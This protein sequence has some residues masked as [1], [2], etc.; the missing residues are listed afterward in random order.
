[1]TLLLFFFCFEIF[2]FLLCTTQK[3]KNRHMDIQSTTLTFDPDYINS[4]NYIPSHAHYPPLLVNNIIARFNLNVEQLNLTALA[5][6]FG[7]NVLPLKYGSN[8]RTKRKLMIEVRKR[9]DQRYS[10][11]PTPI[12]ACIEQLKH[13]N[14]L[15]EMY[16]RCNQL[17]R[18]NRMRAS[19]RAGDYAYKVIDFTEPWA[20]QCTLMLYA[21][22]KC[23]VSGIRSEQQGLFVCHSFVRY[24]VETCHLPVELRDFEIR[25]IACD[26]QLGYDVDL[27]ALADAMPERACYDPKVYPACIIYDNVDQSLVSLVYPNGKIVET[28]AKSYAQNIPRHHNI[29]DL[30]A[31]FRV[32]TGDVRNTNIRDIREARLTTDLHK[33]N[34]RQLHD[35]NQILRRLT[36]VRKLETIDEDDDNNNN[37]GD[38]DDDSIDDDIVNMVDNEESVH[39]MQVRK[40]TEMQQR[41]I[42]R[43]QRKH[44]RI[45][46]KSNTGVSTLDLLNDDDDDDNTSSNVGRKRKRVE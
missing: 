27:R 28:G 43:A 45:T 15:D 42:D 25:N 35:A 2:L 46:S 39:N 36:N 9:S 6:K 18:L 19:I 8:N 24:L 17:T 41:M 22:G 5:Q 3:Q 33:Q 34:R 26:T 11:I 16:H 21:G 1:M 7:T 44:L 40:Q 13:H 38:D 10:H 29:V 31:Q 37:G 12:T 4:L 30:C 23:S 20:P 32:P 14:L